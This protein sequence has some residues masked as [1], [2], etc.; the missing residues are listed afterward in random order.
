MRPAPGRAR[1]R[2]AAGHVGVDQAYLRRAF[3]GYLGE[4]QAPSPEGACSASHRASNRAA[5]VSGGLRAQERCRSAWSRPHRRLGPAAGHGGR[6]RLPPRYAEVTPKSSISRPAGGGSRCG[7]V[8]ADPT[9]HPGFPGE[10]NSC[11]GPS[12]KLAGDITTG[13]VSPNGSVS[14][15]TAIA[16][17]AALA[18]AC[19]GSRRRIRICPQASSATPEV[20]AG[21]LH[22]AAGRTIS[23][24]GASEPDPVVMRASTVVSEANEADR[25]RSA[26]RRRDARLRAE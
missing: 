24:T 13:H 26:F 9:S 12:H 5:V 19:S 8:V 10:L 16:A 25:N 11:A 18:P 14:N 2:R 17:S 22:S 3:A 6:W 1:R 7:P 15:I 23:E 4:R 21:G 20:L